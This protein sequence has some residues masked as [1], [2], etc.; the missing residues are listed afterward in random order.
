MPTEKTIAFSEFLD[1][2]PEDRQNAVKS[3]R[4]AIVKNLPKGFE[5]QVT[6]N[7]L[8]CCSS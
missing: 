5:E 7:M 6:A 2:L 4:Q 8:S 1:F 3:I